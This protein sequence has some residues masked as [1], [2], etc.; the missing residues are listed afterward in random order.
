MT[1]LYLA[2]V[3]MLLVLAGCSK[4]SATPVSAAEGPKKVAVSAAHATTR[5]VPAGFDLTGAFAADEQSDIAPLVAGRV[6][7]TPVDAGSFV[8]QGQVI[9]ELDHRDAQLRVDQAKAQLAQAMAAM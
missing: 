5:T 1:R 4:Q 2:L 8:R 3:P 7:S 6:L 9:A